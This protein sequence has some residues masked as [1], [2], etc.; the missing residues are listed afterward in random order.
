VLRRTVIVGSAFAVAAA[1][2]FA[3]SM[4]VNAAP[5]GGACQLNGTASFTPNGPGTS[6]TF[7]YSV[8]GQL[9]SCQSNVSGAPTSGAFGVGQQYVE[10]VTIQTPTGPQVVQATYAAPLASGAG[11]VPVNS[12]PGGQTSGT[13]VAT[14]P[15]NSTTIVS[16]TTA[17]A[18]PAV[19][20]QG[21]VVASVTLNL[22]SGPAGSPST[23]VL[24]GTNPSF[25][26]NDGVQGAVAFSTS[27]P[28]PCT[29]SGGL[30]SVTLQ[31]TVGIGS[32]S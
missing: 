12:C 21:T 18:G 13:A 4:P 22:V 32:A 26:V 27:D 24:S 8:N 15:D 1:C 29:T 16:Y 10:S 14:W 28:T 5:G 7:N 17:S 20:L 25:P 11:A 23:Y 31:G 19:N 3:V 30:A 2:G 9:S 6:S